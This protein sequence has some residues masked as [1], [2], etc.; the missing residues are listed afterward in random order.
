MTKLVMSLFKHEDQVVDFGNGYH[1]IYVLTGTI[2]IDGKTIDSG[3]GTYVK[4]G[5]DPEISFSDDAEIL[6]YNL[7]SQSGY[8]SQENAIN[9]NVFEI[10]DGPLIFRFDQVSFP[11]GSC[12]YRHVHPGAGIRYLKEG[13]MEIVSDHDTKII[14]TGKTWF[15][16]VDYPVRANPQNSVFA[17]FIRAMVIPAKYKG[18]STIQYL[19]EADKDLPKL[20]T[21]HR[22]F[23]LPISL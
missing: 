6:R 17:S 3:D 7:Q 13:T 2:T 5:D 9:E 15:E 19:N 16:A 14:E 18:L 11:V 21:T 8:I 4:S 23:D 1:A 20:Q 10:A 22:F 12:A